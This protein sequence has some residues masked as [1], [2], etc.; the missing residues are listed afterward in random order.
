[1]NFPYEISRFHHTKILFIAGARAPLLHMLGAEE[2]D[3]AK[4]GAAWVGRTS[5]LSASVFKNQF[6][7]YPRTVLFVEQMLGP[8]ADRSLVL[9]C[10]WWLKTYPTDVEIANKQVSAADFRKKR[11]V[12][13]SQLDASLPEVRVFSFLNF[14]F[15]AL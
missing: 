7:V 2:F 4:A 8:N 3:L 9:R 11:Q 6:G 12:M 15:F 10:L 14:F 1:M 5:K 13:C